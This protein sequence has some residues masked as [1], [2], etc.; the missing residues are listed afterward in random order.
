MGPRQTRS[1]TFATAGNRKEAR[2]WRDVKR[3]ILTSLTNTPPAVAGETPSD[4]IFVPIQQDIILPQIPIGNHHP[5]PRTGIE[6]DDLRTLHTNKFYANVFL[7]AQNQPVTTY[8][9]TIWWG[10]GAQTQGLVQ[11]WGM[12]I[13]HVEDG[14]LVYG[15][16]DPAKVRIA[17]C[18]TSSR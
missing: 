15:P 12:N 4:D 3:S 18:K 9:Y 7:G 17:V 6:D 14:D 8:P 5:V 2:S 1:L 11:T 10:K 16:G 13:S